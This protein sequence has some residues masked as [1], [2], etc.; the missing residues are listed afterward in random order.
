MQIKLEAEPTFIE[1]SSTID[2]KSFLIE[3]FNSVTLSTTNNH[4]IF[5]FIDNKVG[6]IRKSDMTFHKEKSF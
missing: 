2:T 5:D 6:C 3:Q 4:I 1:F